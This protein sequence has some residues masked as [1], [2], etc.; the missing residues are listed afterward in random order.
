MSAYL[1]I[2][3]LHVLCGAT[4]LG[5]TVLSAWFLMPAVGEVG[6]DAAKVMAAL[7]R[8]RMPA[9]IPIV[10][11]TAVLSGIWLYWRFTAGFSPEISGSRGGMAFGLGGAIGI[12]ALILGAAVIS[13]SLVKAREAMMKAVGL[14]EGAERKALMGQARQLQGRALLFARIVGVLLIITV[15][16]MAIGHYV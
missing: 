3:V 16:L 1:V 15:S 13:R 8:R 6:P 7:E 9:V 11:T 4:W 14:P 10:A 12:V 5:M 2:R